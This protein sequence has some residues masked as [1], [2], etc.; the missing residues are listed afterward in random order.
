MQVTVRHAA[1]VLVMSADHDWQA[2]VR[3]VLEREGY[4]VLAARHAG[5]A[6]VT[7]VRHSGPVDLVI[8]DGSL[9]AENGLAPL[10]RE[11]P[12]LRQLVLDRRPATSDELL[13]AVRAA[14]VRH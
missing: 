3:R 13:G 9:S 4:G 7:C 14:L 8:A 2:D 12:G 1:T 5:H 11:Q 10:T 6:L